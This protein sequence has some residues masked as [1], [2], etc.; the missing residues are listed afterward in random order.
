[1]YHSITIG[2]KNTWSD[3]HLIPA[4]RPLVNPP[5]VNTSIVQIPG[6]DGALDITD[7]LVGRPTYGNRTGTW[8]FYVDNGYG[9]WSERYSDI[10][11]YI[12]GKQLKAVFE[13]DPSFYYEGRF[14]VNEWR[15]DAAYSRISINYNVG[16]Y[17]LYDATE[18]ELW[19]W[20]P[21]NFDTGVIRSYNNIVVRSNKSTTVTIQGD[22]MDIIPLI[23]AKDSGIKMRFN[24]S[25]LISLKRGSY[26]YD[27]VVIQQGTNTFVFTYDG[28]DAKAKVSIKMTGGRF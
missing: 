13:D 17:K 26:T 1:M 6:V 11:A 3:W 14:S 8:D 12:H 10:M 27:D 18:G 16:P 24:G 20:D 19:L 5:G 7:A 9:A 28:S 23:V 2:N 15:S 4:S 21:F 25:S 22:I